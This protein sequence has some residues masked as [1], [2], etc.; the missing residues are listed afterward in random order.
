LRKTV[1]AER[2][3]ELSGRLH[4]LVVKHFDIAESEIEAVPVEEIQRIHFTN[5]HLELG[6]KE[7]ALRRVDYSH[8]IL[9][10][11]GEIR[12][13]RYRE[14]RMATPR[15]ASRP[16]T[17]GQQLHIYAI[18]SREAYEL[19]PEQF[20]WSVLGEEQSPSTPLNLKRLIDE[21]GRRSPRMEIDRGFDWEPAVLTRAAADSEVDSMLREEKSGGGVMHDNQS[22]FR[23]YSRWRYLVALE[24]EKG[25]RVE[26]R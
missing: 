8:L 15:G 25:R 13:E 26:E 9:L 4:E 6:L 1:N 21:L 19:D 5:E 7:G 10:V 17:P 12:R 16:L 11:Q 2:A 14:R 22:Q 3:R 18:D 20:D 23:Y 24:E